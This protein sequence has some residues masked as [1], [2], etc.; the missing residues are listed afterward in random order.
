MAKTPVYLT[1]CPHCGKKSISLKPESP[2]KCRHEK[3]EAALEGCASRKPEPR[4]YGAPAFD[5]S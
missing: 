5:E 1:Q 3:I 4:D 2:C